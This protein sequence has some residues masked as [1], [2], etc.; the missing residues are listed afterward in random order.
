MPTIIRYE[1]FGLIAGRLRS[2]EVSQPD[3]R[4]V[5]DM[6]EELVGKLASKKVTLLGL[7]FKPGTDDMREAASIRVVNELLKRGVI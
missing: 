3:M 2:T 6:A 5:V 7:A 4:I 1:A